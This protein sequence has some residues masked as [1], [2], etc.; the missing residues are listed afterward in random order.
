MNEHGQ[1]VRVNFKETVSVNHW[2]ALRAGQSREWREDELTDELRLALSKLGA[3]E[4]H[5]PLSSP[6]RAAI[7]GHADLSAVLK[8]LLSLSGTPCETSEDPRLLDS[9][10]EYVLVAAGYFRKDWFRHAEEAF[11]ATG[12][13]WAP[14]YLEGKLVR[15]GPLMG[16]YLGL[17]D[18]T[19]RLLSA[20]S[21]PDVLQDLWTHAEKI[22]YPSLPFTRPEQH[23]LG[24]TISL[25]LEEWHS[26][27]SMSRGFPPD[28]YQ[29][30]L[31]PM[32]REI[33]Y[34]PILR[35]P[36]SATAERMESL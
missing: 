29:V 10:T 3:E 35:L 18:L 6:V 24:A 34:H 20:S 8:T 15:F 17:E 4:Q 19:T 30:T 13:P 32:T 14:L 31:V 1:L 28:R 27:R 25:L 26:G 12:T 7:V 9:R 11:H 33:I 16:P 21:S 36:S 2:A 22:N 23:W 5:P